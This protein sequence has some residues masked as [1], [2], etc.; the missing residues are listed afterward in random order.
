MEIKIKKTIYSTLLKEE[1][2]KIRQ[3]REHEIYP[4][5]K[6][7]IN[8][9]IRDE[10]FDGQNLFS[11]LTDALDLVFSVLDDHGYVLKPTYEEQP[12]SYN[13][14]VAK[15]G[16]LNFDVGFKKPNRMSVGPVMNARLNFE[17]LKDDELDQYQVG[18][19]LV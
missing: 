2:E 1:M 16:N 17:W 14:L 11:G 9:A 10:G 18:C 19:Q 8:K 7:L 13:Q 12:I 5:I 4:S 3:E 6:F 15:S